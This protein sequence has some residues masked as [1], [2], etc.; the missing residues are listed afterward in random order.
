MT[1]F[2]IS[3]QHY[4][5]SNILKFVS[6]DGKSELVRPGFSDVNEMNEI[7]I[8]RHNAVVNDTDKVYHLGDFGMGIRNLPS[9]LSRLKGH[10]R[11]ILGN[12]DYTERKDFEVYFQFFEKIMES[13]RMG[14]IL[15]TH[16]PTYLG[17][18][19]SRIR[20][21]V[22]GHIHEKNLPDPRYLNISV[23]QTN[24]TPISIDEIESILKK[25]GI[26]ISA[27]P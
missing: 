5:H 11:L 3:D 12:H 20:A 27:V 15:F 23:E 19:E 17:P 6:E 14:P 25:R 2:F 22:H 13:R 9:V 16:R 21:N 8:E 10:K 7:M 24:Y 1:I 26:D 4:F 18:H